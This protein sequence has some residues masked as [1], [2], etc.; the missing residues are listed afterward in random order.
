MRISITDDFV[1][2]GVQYLLRYLHEDRM[3]DVDEY[4][5]FMRPTF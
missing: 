2:N 4:G 5:L 1:M 3:H